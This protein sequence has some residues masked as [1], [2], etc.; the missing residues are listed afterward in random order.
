M[1]VCVEC[2]VFSGRGLCDGLITRP[3]KS[4]R[5]WCV[6]VC[7]LETSRMRRTWSAL[8]RSGRCVRLRTY[9]HPVPLSRNL[10]TLTSWNPLGLS[11]LV[12]G[13][14]Y[15]TKSLHIFIKYVFN[16][17]SVGINVFTALLAYFDAW[18][19]ETNITRHSRTKHLAAQGH[20]PQV[21]VVVFK[22]S[23][24]FRTQHISY[25]KTSELLSKSS[26]Y[27]SM[28]LNYSGLAES[29]MKICQRSYNINTSIFILF[30]AE[31]FVFNSFFLT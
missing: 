10:G 30:V 2:Y 11:R 28:F 17:H 24:K 16:M 26:S 4:Y 19:W 12:M 18:N 14:L 29:I 13:L 23:L 15:F 5:L 27:W 21:T 25:I 22:F 7:D 3:E 6:V 8:D 9:H 20:F 1:D 31:V